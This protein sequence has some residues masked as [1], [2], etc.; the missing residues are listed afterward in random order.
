[1]GNNKDYKRWI[2]EMVANINDRFKASDNVK[3]IIE[4][5]S[6]YRA[7][8]KLQ[9]PTQGRS[10]VMSSLEVAKMYYYLGGILAASKTEETLKRLIE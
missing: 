10:T 1:M 4:Y 3:Y 8:L 7:V 9:T 5:Q 6:N 2:N